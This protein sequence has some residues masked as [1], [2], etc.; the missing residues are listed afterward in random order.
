MDSYVLP[1]FPSSGTFGS[2]RTDCSFSFPVAEK[3]ALPIKST[4]SSK[5]S[6]ATAK[7]EGG[8]KEVEVLIID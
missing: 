6:K 2:L 3:Y 4:S 1:L 5:P 7:P 8:K